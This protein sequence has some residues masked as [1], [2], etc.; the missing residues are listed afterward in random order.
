MIEFGKLIESDPIT[1]RSGLRM[2]VGAVALSA[3]RT[4]HYASLFW[5]AFHPVNG[6]DRAH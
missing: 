1:I 2:A 3:L 4:L 6:T 5:S